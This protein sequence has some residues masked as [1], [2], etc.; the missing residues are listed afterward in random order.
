V[1]HDA[2][3]LSGQRLL[4][5]APSLR[6]IELGLRAKSRQTVVTSMKDLA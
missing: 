5:S 4:H 3:C 1:W 2:K 6:L